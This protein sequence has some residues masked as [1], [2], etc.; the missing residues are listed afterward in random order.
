MELP[1]EG[2]SL[3][4]TDWKVPTGISWQG[5]RL[6][7]LVGQALGGHL[8]V[9]VHPDGQAVEVWMLDVQP[10]FQR[11]GLGSLLMDTLYAAYPTA[12]INHGA[13]TREGTWWWNSYRE[14]DPQRNVHNRPPAEWAVYFDAVEVASDKAQNAH[15]NAFYGLDGHRQDAYRYGE[16]LDQEADGYA[17]FHLPAQAAGLDPAGRQLHG[18]TRLLLPPGLHAYVHDDTRDASERAAALLEHLGHGNLPRTFWNST[19]HAA[20][21]DAH[22]EEI[23]QGTVPAQAATH[24]VFT[25]CPRA[26]DRLPAFDALPASMYFVAHTDIAV[27]LSALAWRSAG[28]PAVTHTA[29][30]TPPVAAAIAPHWPQDASAAYRARYSEAGFLLPSN[31]PQPAAEPAYADRAEDIRAVAEGLLAAQA[32]RSRSAQPPDAPP[33]PRQPQQTSPPPAPR[34]GQGLR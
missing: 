13:R 20:F 26:A 9:H 21:E 30:F 3:W 19:Q 25:L 8:D 10:G 24:L 5:R 32:E 29:A 7:A 15:L 28:Q 33:L 12:W 31:A 22:H 2:L 4:L 34:R 6:V 1:E 23:F 14:P 27:E 11:R 18:A 16:R 17:R